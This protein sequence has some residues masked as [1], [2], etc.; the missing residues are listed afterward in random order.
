MK[1]ALPLCAA[2]LAAFAAFAAHA[3]PPAAANATAATAPTTST[4]AA[5]SNT[6]A[7]LGLELGKSKCARLAP[8]ENHVRT[9]KS[10]W[11]G[12]DAV[13][14]KR[15]ERFHLPGLTRVTL[16]CDAQDTV[17]LITMTFDRSALDD[18]RGKLDARYASLRKTEASAENGYA[19]WAAAN[20]SLELL[21]GRDGKHF[22]VAY[23][24][25][26]AKAKYF[27]YSG[28]GSKPAAASAPAAPAAAQPAPL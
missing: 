19:E 9:G 8:A 23:W 20:G 7:P 25:R 27:S 24:A 18:V 22:T 2:L 10:E 11:A 21:Y 14:L 26:N 4:T 28:A 3:A 15:L 12:G 13:E 6:A 5:A 16:N 1:K 17:A